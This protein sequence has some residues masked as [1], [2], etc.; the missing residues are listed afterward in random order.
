M[1]N[2]MTGAPTAGRSATGTGGKRARARL[3]PKVIIG[4]LILIAAIWFIVVNRARVE[5]Y[6]WVPK[7][8]APLWLVLLI[9]FAAGALTE[10]LLQRGR[11]KRER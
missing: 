5:I 2:T 7:V 11:N 9:T 8:T 1:G 4:G 3:S 6:L 10:I